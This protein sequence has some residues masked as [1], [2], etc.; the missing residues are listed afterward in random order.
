VVSAEDAPSFVIRNLPSGEIQVSTG[1]ILISLST[2]RVE[3]REF[4]MHWSGRKLREEIHLTLLS[5]PSTGPTVTVRW[6]EVATP[7]LQRHARQVISRSNLLKQLMAD[8]GSVQPSVRPMR[9]VLRDNVL[10]QLNDALQ[11]LPPRVIAKADVSLPVTGPLPSSEIFE[12]L[13]GP[14]DAIENPRID[15]E[16]SVGEEANPV[17]R[18]RLDR[19]L[20]RRLPAS[21]RAF[22]SGY[23][24]AP[25]GWTALQKMMKHSSGRVSLVQ[26]KDLIDHQYREANAAGGLLLRYQALALEPLSDLIG[27]ATSLL[28]R[29]AAFV[30]FDV[31]PS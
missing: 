16:F 9:K 29:G 25:Q 8:D 10:A 6:C 13:R 23:C 15:L 11:A 3:Y 22:L 12:Q 31:Q 19:P 26:E 28:D 17:L 14:I 20:G 5:R 4:I 2:D 30:Y 24:G 18:W 27:R 21:A 1:G 7:S